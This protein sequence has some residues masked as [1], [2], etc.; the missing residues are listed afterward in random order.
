MTL[1]FSFLSFAFFALWLGK[2]E[3]A[4]AVALAGLVCAL[5]LFKILATDMLQI[6]W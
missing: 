5:V 6:M 4:I 1:V 3:W 2:R